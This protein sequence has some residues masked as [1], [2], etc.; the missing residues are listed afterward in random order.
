MPHL[1]ERF[2]CVESAPFVVEADAFLF[3]A[4]HHSIHDHE[5]QGIVHLLPQEFV[6]EPIDVHDQRVAVAADEKSYGLT[7]LDFFAE[8]GGENGEFARVPEFFLDFAEHRGEHRS[9]NLRHQD[10]HTVGPSGRQ[11]LGDRIGTVVQ[12]GHGRVHFIASLVA[13]AGTAVD[14]A[15]HGGHGNAHQLRYFVNR[16]HGYCCSCLVAILLNVRIVSRQLRHGVV[17]SR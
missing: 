16:C 7:L 12:F 5:R 11:G 10:S 2:R 8:A 14:D 3:Q 1:Q 15:R 17:H 9:V 4:G 13:H 6:R